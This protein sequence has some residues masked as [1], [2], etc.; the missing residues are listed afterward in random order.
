[1]GTG[2]KAT[3]LLETLGSELQTPT[4]YDQHRLTKRWGTTAMSMADFCQQLRD[5][6][7]EASRT[8]Y[9]GTT[10]KTDADVTEIRD[11]VDL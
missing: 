2:Q 10:F 8:H 4:H 11:A 9:G 3:E 6:G 5:A 1:M 7:Y